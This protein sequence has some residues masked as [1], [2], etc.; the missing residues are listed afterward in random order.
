MATKIK[1][2]ALRVSKKRPGTASSANGAKPKVKPK[3]KVPISA[4]EDLPYYWKVSEVA[5]RLRVH[6]TTVVR[7]FRGRSGVIEPP[8]GDSQKSMLIS[9][10]AL[11]DYLIESGIDPMMLSVAV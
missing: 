6:P 10:E 8:R 4:I 7:R 3:P 11:V 9:Q 1:R 5:K 2:P